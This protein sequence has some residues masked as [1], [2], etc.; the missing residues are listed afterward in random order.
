MGDKFITHSHHVMEFKMA[1]INCKE[2][3]K[4]FSDLAY[5]CPKCAA[6]AAYST[7]NPSDI[8]H[9]DTE[10]APIPFDLLQSETYNKIMDYY[11]SLHSEIKKLGGKVPE[12][13]EF[14]EE[15]IVRAVI[16]R[17]VRLK[18]MMLTISSFDGRPQIKFIPSN[19]WIIDSESIAKMI[20]DPEG[21][22]KELL[23]EIIQS[24]VN[25]L[26]NKR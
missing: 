23:P 18:R 3:G 8:Q 17:M 26:A 13:P 11:W 1:L 6:P 7:G 10:T 2:C 20:G 9:Q 24:A 15:E 5:A 22:R 16:T 21:P 4:K 19:C 12:Y 14:K 25:R